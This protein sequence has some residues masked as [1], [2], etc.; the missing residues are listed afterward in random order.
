MRFAP[1]AQR[2]RAFGCGPR[3]LRFE[4]CRGYHEVFMFKISLLASSENGLLGYLKFV[5]LFPTFNSIFVK[6]LENNVREHCRYIQESCEFI[7]SSFNKEKF[8]NIIDSEL[9]K[10]K[11][12]DNS[13]FLFQE[14]SLQIRVLLESVLSGI[15]PMDKEI[16]IGLKRTVC[17]TLFGIQEYFPYYQ[18]EELIDIYNKILK[19]KNKYRQFYEQVLADFLVFASSTMHY[20]YDC[21]ELHLE[22]FCKDLYK[23]FSKEDIDK[24]QDKKVLIVLPTIISENQKFF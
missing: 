8:R 24:Y 4:S 13:L 1:V 22:K 5:I 21:E 12:D 14:Q 3:G 20:P 18:H 6:N 16:F 7:D 9:S 10:R 15:F 11:F 2:I 23:G 19:I 17:D